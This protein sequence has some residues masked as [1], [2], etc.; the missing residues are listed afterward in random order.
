MT[1]IIIKKQT[2][3]F[4]V[5]ILLVAGAM[6]AVI[7]ANNVNF[8]YATNENLHYQSEFDYQQ[9][10]DNYNLIESL[11]AASTASLQLSNAANA[12]NVGGSLTVFV[13][14]QEGRGGD[15]EKNT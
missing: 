1:K 15:Y 7:F 12:G 5:L 3:I 6:L 2:T 10:V 13:H 11:S 9:E 14:G 8:A 4:L